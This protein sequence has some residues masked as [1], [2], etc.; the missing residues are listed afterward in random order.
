[1]HFFFHNVYFPGC[2]PCIIKHL[3]QALAMWIPQAISDLPCFTLA[4][5]NRGFCCD[6][7]ICKK[8]TET[9]F[10]F[11]S[12]SLGNEILNPKRIK[13]D[14]LLLCYWGC[15]YRLNVHEFH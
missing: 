8:V 6:T 7:F 3:Y 15:N 4:E 10:H 1:M 2:F 9:S 13:S 14:T 5:M 11:P 12:T